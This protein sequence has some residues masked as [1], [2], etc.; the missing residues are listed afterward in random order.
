MALGHSIF[1]RFYIFSF[2]NDIKFNLRN[3]YGNNM[4]I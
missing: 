4:L 2:V 3:S 1:C